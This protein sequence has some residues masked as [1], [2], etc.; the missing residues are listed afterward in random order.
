MNGCDHQP[1]QTDLSQAIKTAQELYPDVE[2]KHS[3]F[4]EYIEALHEKLADDMTTIT[5][6]LR[7]QQ[8]DGWYTLANTASARIYI[9]QMNAKCQM[10]LEKWLNR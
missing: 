10:M 1:V 5:G 6:E 7:S 3:N 4:E 8:T 2:F 9:K